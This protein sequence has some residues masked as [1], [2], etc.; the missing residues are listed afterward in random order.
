MISREEQQI[1]KAKI[2]INIFLLRLL[3]V[4]GLWLMH[5]WPTYVG[6]IAGPAP[7][8]LSR[9]PQQELRAIRRFTI[10][11][12]FSAEIA[13]CGLQYFDMTVI[14]GCPYPRYTVHV[15]CCYPMTAWPGF[16]GGL[17]FSGI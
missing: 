4:A 15:Y 9:H 8:R 2:N 1:S 17:D 11:R 5:Q 7:L 12:R 14:L 10:L 16:T 6:T 3:L 13:L